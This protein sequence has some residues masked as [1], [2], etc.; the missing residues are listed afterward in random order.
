[1]RSGIRVVSLILLAPAS[2]VAASASAQSLTPCIQEVRLSMEREVFLNSPSHARPAYTATIK[3]TYE[4]T[5][6]DGN[7]IHWTVEVVQARDEAGRTMS[8]HIQGC[9]PD[10]SGQ[11]QLRMLTTVH[12]PVAKTFLNWNTGPGSV[13]LANL[14]H[15]MQPAFPSD[16]KDI[17]RIPWKPQRAQITRE[18]LGTQ[19]VA[20]LEATGSRITQII[21]AGQE[22]NDMPLKVVHE[23]WS[24]AKN[25]S[26]LMAIDDDPRTG[27]HIW[28]VESLTVG[29]P[30]PAL[31]VPPANYKV[32]DETSRP[33]T[34]ADANR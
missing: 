7:A 4:Q 27:H 1:M 12:D 26:T 20:G 23:T 8:Q 11:P 34:T 28:E 30:D 31:F 15:Q 17:P 9:A 13:A 16:L 19:T 33:Q 25:H 29:P 3:Q 24:D 21:P 32:W 6:P 5:F 14:Q 2:L 10:D 18:S 22:G